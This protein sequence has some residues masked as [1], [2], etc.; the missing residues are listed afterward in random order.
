MRFNYRWFYLPIARTCKP[1]AR[2]HDEAT[3]AAAHAR[4]PSALITGAASLVVRDRPKCAVAVLLSPQTPS[5]GITTPLPLLD[6]GCPPRRA[7]RGAATDPR[8]SPEA[9]GVT[10][11]GVI[12]PRTGPLLVLQRDPM[13]LHRRRCR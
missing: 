10:K 12:R 7:L 2:Q 8:R 9:A 1:A 13:H 5:L 3:L 11:A 4:W 6:L